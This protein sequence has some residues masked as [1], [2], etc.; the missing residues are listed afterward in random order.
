MKVKLLSLP[1]Q[2]E[3]A[4]PHFLNMP[5]PIYPST[6]DWGRIQVIVDEL[7]E[8]FPDKFPDHTLSE[9]EISYRAGQLSIIRILKEKLK[10]E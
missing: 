1:T 3:L 2:N 4:C 6:L 5:T 10:G 9:K 8:Q 7:D